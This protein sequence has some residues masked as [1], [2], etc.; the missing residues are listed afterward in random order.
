MSG[1]AL[2][3]GYGNPLRADDGLGWQVGQQLAAEVSSDE[4]SVMPVHQLTPELAE[5]ISRARL[6]VFVDAREGPD[7]GQ[8]RCE[9]VRPASQTDPS[10]SHDLDPPS[11]LELARILYGQCPHAVLV[12]VDGDDFGYG[13]GLSPVVRAAVPEVI[14]MVTALLRDLTPDPSPAR[15]GETDCVLPLAAPGR[16]LRG[17][18]H[19]AGGGHAHA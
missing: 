11:V 8:V 9:E 4:V 15:R 17:E 1:R 13:A 12:T 6:A 3:I 18:V 2:V 5:P 7:P 14:R 16:R 10:F 19:Q